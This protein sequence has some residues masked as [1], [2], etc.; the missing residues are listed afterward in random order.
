MPQLVAIKGLINTLLK[1]DQVAKVQAEEDIKLFGLRDLPGDSNNERP[2]SLALQVEDLLEDID[3]L[4]APN[5][6]LN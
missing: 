2:L 1:V 6:L 5:N 4:D 3:M